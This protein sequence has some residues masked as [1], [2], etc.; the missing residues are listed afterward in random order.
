MLENILSTLLQGWTKKRE[1]FDVE[2]RNSKIFQMDVIS[3][4]VKKIFK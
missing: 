2:T 4:G 1:V 3:S